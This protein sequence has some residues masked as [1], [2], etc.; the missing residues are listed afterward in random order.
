MLMKTIVGIEMYRSGA[1]QKVICEH[2]FFFMLWRENIKVRK[3][4]KNQESIQSST[5]PDQEYHMVK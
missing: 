1:S 3:G 5:T 2:L 4:A